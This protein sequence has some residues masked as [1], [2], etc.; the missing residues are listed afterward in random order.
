[1][2]C[3]STKD[4]QGTVRG[5]LVKVNENLDTL[6][7]KWFNHP[8]TLIASQANP[9]DVFS[10]LSDI[11]ETPDGGYIITGNYNKECI[12]GNVHGFLI[13]TDTSGNILWFKIIASKINP[14][15]VKID[16]SQLKIG[17]YI[18]KA[19]FDNGYIR[20]FKFVVD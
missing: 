18:G 12:N 6:W 9:S 8:D 14:N 1:M 5:I 20:S 3:G 16:V 11:K 17:L 7:T 4:S 13:K 19:I 10:A 15:K 2:F